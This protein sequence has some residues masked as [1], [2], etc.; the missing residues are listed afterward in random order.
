MFF[1]ISASTDGTSLNHTAW[2]PYPDFC[3]FTMEWTPP[4]TKII[5]ASFPAATCE[6]AMGIAENASS[7]PY[8][9]WVTIMFTFLLILI[10]LTVWSYQ[11]LPSIQ[12]GHKA[13]RL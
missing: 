8:G 9:G 13:R 4:L 12:P 2:S 11:I 10:T 5:D 1:V 7:F 3:P 6:A